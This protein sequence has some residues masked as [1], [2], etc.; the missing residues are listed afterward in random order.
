MMELPVPARFLPVQSSLLM[1]IFRQ[2]TV[3]V[4]PLLSSG[5]AGPADKRPLAFPGL[6]LP[7]HCLLFCLA[8]R[9]LTRS[10]TLGREP[11]T[12]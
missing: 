3:L 6:S 10:V 2:R 12:R 1:I 8:T 7:C 9:V 5:L 4:C 11:Q